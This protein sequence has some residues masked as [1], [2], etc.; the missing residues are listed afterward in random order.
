MF[1]PSEGVH[2]PTFCISSFFSLRRS[3]LKL[4][5]FPSLN[6]MFPVNPWRPDCK[7][8]HSVVYVVLLSVFVPFNYL[9]GIS[10]NWSVLRSVTNYGVIFA[11]RDCKI[12]K[13]EV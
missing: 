9:Y 7:E 4:E 6:S 13:T 5:R 12:L 11:L 8:K 2:C 1:I 10:L 3:N